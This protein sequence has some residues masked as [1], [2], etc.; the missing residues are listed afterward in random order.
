MFQSLELKHPKF[1][2]Y[3]RV[4]VVIFASVLYAWNLCCFAKTVGLL[5]GGF[6]GVSLLLQE[7]GSQFFHINVPFTVFNVALNL[8]PVYLGFRYI[9]KK[10]TIY[11]IVTIV[12]SSIF[13]DIL[14][15]YVFTN[16]I[17]LVS[18]FGGLINGFAISLCLNVGTTTCGT[19]FISIFLSEQKG[20][21]A[22]N[23][24]LAGNVIV[25]GIAGLLFGWKIALYSIIYQ[26]CST[27]VIQLL[28]KRYQ[29]ETLFIISDHAEEIYKAIKET[30]NHDATLFQGIGCYEEKEKTMLY[31]VINSEA[32]RE[33]IPLIRSIDP[34]AFINI[35]KTQE[36]QGRFHN[37]PND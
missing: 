23:Y 24:I 22:W 2:Q 27:Q 37:I 36:L 14:P 26:F 30:T 4:L 9:G 5:P 31:S 1:Y 29:K 33:L 16:D 13:V 7:I 21:D 11:S 12:L 19:D 17:L 28:Y 10:F 6:S 35:V 18:V 32:K 34:H 15:V 3:F 20:I 8:F 25:L